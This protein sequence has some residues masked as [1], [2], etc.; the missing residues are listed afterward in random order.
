[1][2]QPFLV[3]CGHSV[4][5]HLGHVASLINVCWFFFVQWIYL[6]HMCFIYIVVLFKCGIILRGVA[7]IE[8]EVEKCLPTLVIG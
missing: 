8:H 4:V 6:H 2:Q 3:I 5:C 1:M 7:S